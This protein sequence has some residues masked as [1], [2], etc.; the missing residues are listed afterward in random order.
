MQCSEGIQWV[1]RIVG[2]C[3]VKHISNYIIRSFFNSFK[4][5]YY[6]Y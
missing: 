6:C 3:R 5:Y 1:K 2:S 4:A